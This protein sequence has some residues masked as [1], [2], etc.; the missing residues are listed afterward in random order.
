MSPWEQLADP[1]NSTCAQVIH[2]RSQAFGNKWV[3]VITREQDGQ[4]D[5]HGIKCGFYFLDL[6]VGSIYKHA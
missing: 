1:P 4:E 6:I 2:S 5:D 3:P